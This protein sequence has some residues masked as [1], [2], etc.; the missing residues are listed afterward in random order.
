MA[1]LGLAVCAILC[2]AR[3]PYAVSQWG[4]DQGE[5]VAEA[6][7]FTRQRTPCVSTLHQVFSRLDQEAFEC[8]L[9][10]SRPHGLSAGEAVASSPSGR[11]ASVTVQTW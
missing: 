1:I 5:E 6:L 11:C 4:R 10:R 2:G 9:G 8:E 3:S 7:G